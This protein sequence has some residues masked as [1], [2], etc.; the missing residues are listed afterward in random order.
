MTRMDF[1]S[2]QVCLKCATTWSAFWT[3]KL[4]FIELN[5]FKI[6]QINSFTDTVPLQ[7]RYQ[8]DRLLK[9]ITYIKNNIYKLYISH[10]KMGM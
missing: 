3:P 5:K 7:V 2:L 1:Y 8:V 6:I 4:I 9:Y 10:R